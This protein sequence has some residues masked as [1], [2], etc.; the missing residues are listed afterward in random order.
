MSEE[1]ASQNKGKFREKFRLSSVLVITFIIPI[2][3]STGLVGWFSFRNGQRGI[4]QLVNQLQSEAS[5]RV[6]QYLNNY[7]KTPHQINQINLDALNSGLIKLE[8]FR[9]MERVFRKQLQVFQVGYINYANQKGEFIGVTFDSKNR[10]QVVVE[11][12]NRSQSNK[13]SRYATDDK[14]N[15]TNLL[16]TG[17]YDFTLEPWYA[18]AVKAGKPLWS[19]IYR[20][21]GG[22]DNQEILS[23]SSSYPVYDDNKKL[24]GVL[25]I[26]LTL[27]QIS[28]FLHNLKVSPS[29]RIFI[30]ERD[31]LLVANS[32]SETP[33]TLAKGVAQRLNVVN[34]RDPLIK[35]TAQHLQKNFG[36]FKQIKNTQKFDFQ[37]EGGRQLVYAE[38]WRDEF[39]LDWLV[40]V[41]VPESDFM[42]QINR[43]NQ[44]TILL[45]AIAFIAAT[46]IGIFTSGRITR[47]I[48]K[49]SQAS[50][51]IA[52]GSLDRRVAE[53][54][55]IEI[56]KLANSFNSM[57]RQLQESFATLEK[58]NEDLKHLDQL[59]DEFLANTS[60]EL[61]TPL[62]GIIGIAESLIDG[63]TGQLPPATISNLSMIVSSG[64]RLSN[65]V[66]DILD[67][68]K[69]RH[70]NIELQLKP[71]GMREIAEI[72]L[73]LSRPLIGHKNLQLINTIPVLPPA[74]ADENRVQ[75]IMY[76]L[77]GNAIK[78]TKIGTIEVSAELVMGNQQ[79]P[80]PNSQLAITISDTG[81][82][83]P[84][85]KFDRIF[86][87]FEQADGSTGREYGGSGLGLAVT[88]KLVELHGGEITVAST[89]GVGSQFTFTL[90]VW[91]SNVEISSS[92]PIIKAEV[93]SRIQP[94]IFGTVTQPNNFKARK[95]NLN[96]IPGEFK[97]MIVDDE[98]VNL[99]VLANHLYL[100]NYAITQATNGEEALEIIEN[101]FQPDIIV[102]DV[103][104][105][106]MSGYEVT[107]KL[108]DRFPATDLPIL[109]LTAKTQVSDLVE[110]LNV[111]ANDYLT[112]PIAKDELLARIRT[113]LNLRQLRS[114]NIR[115]SAELDVAKR[116]QQM[117][118]PKPEEL[119][120][121]VGLEIAGFMEPADE[122]GGDY[123]DVLNTDGVVTIGIGDVT[124]HGLESG[125]LM[126][127]TQTAVRTLKEIRESDPVLFLDTL[128]RTIYK[129]IQRMN[130]GKNLTLAIL[131]YA[132]GKISISGQHEEIIVVRS[133]GKIERIETMDLGFPIGLESEIY[134]F[135]SHKIVELAPG[136]GVVLYTDG[137]P[138]AEDIN[139]KFYGLERLTDVV[140]MNWHLS[141][142]EIKQ[143][144]ISDLRQFIGEQKVFDDITLVILKRIGSTV[145]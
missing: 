80:I 57:A 39:G 23:I 19:K 77:V 29:G 42:A 31:G 27:S 8:D 99:Q 43:N 9:T 64:R 37:L 117:V 1:V 106:R 20:W 72:V 79:L 63:V 41:V 32:S 89:V 55:I 91:Q 128:N 90:P 118:L 112:K 47:P 96:P 12:F 78:F 7:L 97:I 51:E 6:H 133:G 143:A 115:L 71:V 144:A 134:D 124:G 40:V 73:T 142:E 137:I 36:N 121:I 22:G 52:V 113:H 119:A 138:E 82:G 69:L 120:A 70:T 135:I 21:T 93:K 61:R 26:D 13:L 49:I 44:T 34:S 45:C 60:H 103:M 50:E 86:E 130:S 129:N 107:Q 53:S 10:N 48:L 58:Q 11:V 132:D 108:R 75:Q 88:K 46:A 16:F 84:A 76:N 141:A 85:D 102:L 123:Y 116:L 126:V 111:G 74:N 35:A 68:S 30:I 2:V 14:G 66:N 87:S 101:G 122:V 54:N 28:D 95:K 139:K 15:R 92:I 62:N 125:I 17:E 24:V 140:S 100:Q 4:Q 127:M 136:D 67:F 104:M 38:P 114:E 5:T 33:F 83:I 110:G 3:A 105:P 81:I 56:D 94:V 18:D 109:L 25:G 131:N 145:A 98:P 59:K 65:L